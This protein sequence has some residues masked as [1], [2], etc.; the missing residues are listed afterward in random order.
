M[1][2][3][4]PDNVIPVVFVTANGED[5]IERLPDAIVVA[6]PFLSHALHEAVGVA[7]DNPFVCPS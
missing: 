5:V 2:A 7:Q 6:K 4:C 1:L 3:I